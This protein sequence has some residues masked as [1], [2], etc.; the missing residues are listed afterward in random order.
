MRIDEIINPSARHLIP[1][2]QTYVR[3]IKHSVANAMNRVSRM[4]TVTDKEASEAVCLSFIQQ[5]VD[6][7]HLV[8]FALDDSRDAAT[9]WSGSTTVEPRHADRKVTVVVPG[10]RMAKLLKQRPD[11]IV[12]QVT[13]VLDH[14]FVHVQQDFQDPHIH[15][16]EH[17]ERAYLT[18]EDEIE[19]YVEEVAQELF[20][21]FGSQAP[22]MI[23]TRDP[24]IWASIRDGMRVLRSYYKVTLPA[25]AI[26]FAVAVSRRV[27]EL[28]DERKKAARAADA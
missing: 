3:K 6:L 14:E 8:Q 20:D 15:R 22:E 24:D 25:E 13:S 26:K 23:G 12:T 16:A 1:D 27:K 5:F 28:V 19:A 4:E 21:T 7:K 17:D 18:G 9:L 10:I 11:F 2:R